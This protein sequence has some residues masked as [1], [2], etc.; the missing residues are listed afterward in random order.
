MLNSGGAYGAAKLWPSEYFAELA[1]R[2][3][4]E[5]GL[6]VLVNCGPAE[7][8]VAARDRRAGRSSARGRP[9]RRSAFDRADQGL[10]PPQPAAGEHRQRSAVSSRVAFGVPV[11]SL[12]GPTHMQWTRTHYDRRNLP[13]A[14][15]AVR[16]LR[17]PHVSAGPPR[18]HASLAV[19]RVYAAVLEQLGRKYVVRRVT[20]C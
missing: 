5:Q 11:V 8:A 16:T 1:R 15:R 3:A 6:A 14:R 10:H 19:E 7:R 9:G 18:M 13:A 4:T 20:A 12:F 17:P 2:I